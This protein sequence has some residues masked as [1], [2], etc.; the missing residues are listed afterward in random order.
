M[1]GGIWSN[2]SLTLENGTL[3]SCNTDKCE[4]SGLGSRV[5][6]RK[7][8]HAFGGAVYIAGGT[9]SIS[10]TTFTGNSAQGC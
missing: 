9:A 6:L 1:G 7:A 10:D 3:F 5:R 2:G 4:G 8:S